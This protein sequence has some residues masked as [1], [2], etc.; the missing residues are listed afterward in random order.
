MYAYGTTKLW[1]IIVS[2][3]LNERLKGTGVESFA[4]HPGM[5]RTGAA[6]TILLL[7]GCM[8]PHAPRHNLLAAAEVETSA[9]HSAL[10]QVVLAAAMNPAADH[11]LVAHEPTCLLPGPI[12]WPV[13]YPQTFSA[14]AT[15]A[16][17]RP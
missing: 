8:Q 13:P 9:Q 12:A 14:R 16:S 17:R 15:P 3:E 6:H 7:V 11:L 5:C 2:Q 4:C 10:W 1:E